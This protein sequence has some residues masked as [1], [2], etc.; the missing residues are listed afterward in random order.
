[1]PD[2]LARYSPMP[3]PACGNRI[4]RL[5]SFQSGRRAYVVSR[6]GIGKRR[7]CD[8]PDRTITTRDDRTRVIEIST[9]QCLACERTSLPP[10]AH[11]N[12]QAAPTAVQFERTLQSGPPLAGT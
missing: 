9:T 3:D 10:V 6:A 2:F 1:M 5:D 4:F 7:G 11:R 12:W 8:R